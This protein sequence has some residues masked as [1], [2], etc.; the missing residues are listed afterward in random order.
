[1]A[2]ATSASAAPHAYGGGA[3]A[4]AEHD[5]DAAGDAR[6]R[7]E[8]D[9]RAQAARGP[10]LE[11][12]LAAGAAPAYRGLGA[13][14]SFHKVD[15]TEAVAQ[16][17]ARGTLG[18]TRAPT[19]VRGICRVDYQPDVCKD[20]K[21]TGVCGFGDSCK[22]LHDRSDYKSGWQ[23]ELD[24]QAKQKRKQARLAARL[25]A[26]GTLADEGEGGGD[27]DDDDEGAGEDGEGGGGAGGAKTGGLL[28]ASG[29]WAAGV[30]G[31]NGKKLVG[32]GTGE[33]TAAAAAAAAAA[34]VPR[35]RKGGTGSAGGTG[36]SADGEELPHACFLC[37]GAFVAPVATNCG[38]YFCEAC[39]LQRHRA[40]P[41]CAVCGKPTQ[42]IFNAAPKLAA[43]VRLR[44]AASAEAGEAG[45]R[46]SA[47]A[48]PAAGEAAGGGG[49]GGGWATVT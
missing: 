21:E 9:L 33:P 42:G 46:G 7:L 25:A 30:V 17:K 38:H 24:W 48:E 18:P 16:A 49:G 41:L 22:Y 45:D 2:Y 6:A 37:R 13:Y 29:L 34:A 26:G 15:A 1:M 32:A 35:R 4:Y 31:A 11:A 5:A 39:A 12:A 14:A 23:I 10:E 40:H 47:A 27:N 28:Q 36:A 44:E 8:R 20:F 19:N 43:L 3:F